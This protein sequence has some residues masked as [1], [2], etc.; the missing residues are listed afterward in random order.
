M[1]T[2]RGSRDVTT[3]QSPAQF[4]LD[5]R[6]W[7]RSVT[8]KPLSALTPRSRSAAYRLTQGDAL[9]PLATLLEFVEA[10]VPAG[11]AAEGKQQWL[12]RAQHDWTERWTA[13]NDYRRHSR[14]D[15]SA[16]EAAGGLPEAGA[17]LPVQD[18]LPALEHVV[19]DEELRSI[20]AQ[21]VY[22][23]ATKTPVGYHEKHPI[24]VYVDLHTASCDPGL[25]DQLAAYL[26][27]RVQPRVDASV[28]GNLA[29][30][31]PREGSVLVGSKVAELLGVPFL[32][33]R[34][35]RAPRFG[36]PIEGTFRSGMEAVII[37]D[38][39]MGS[40]VA[41]TARLLRQYGLNVSTCFS[42]FERVDAEPRT[43]LEEAGIELDCAWQ[44]DDKVLLSLRDSLAGPERD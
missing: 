18:A 13:T 32:M 29:L 27:S 5:F 23:A 9:M 25:R 8:G 39:V 6:A 34:T 40:L 11:L 41:R 44:I 12:Q 22:V 14:V 31:T 33:V 3:D 42:I 1:S 37:D 2:I 38:L 24:G 30:A 21:H 43:Y 15:P 19:T 16:H 35:K 28:R 20:A 36:Y 17:R 7:V 26:A 4:N 10:C